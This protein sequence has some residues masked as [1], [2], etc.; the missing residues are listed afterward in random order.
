MI[1]CRALE[2]KSMFVTAKGDILPCC[3]MYRSGPALNSELR[4]VVEDQNFEKLVASWNT[5]KPFELCR[6]TCSTK[7]TSPVSMTAFKNQWKIIGTDNL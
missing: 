4:Q 2:E 3:Y 5:D 6:I 1:K 7:S